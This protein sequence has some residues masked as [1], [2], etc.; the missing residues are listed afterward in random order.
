MELKH[1]LYTR[2]LPGLLGRSVRAVLAAAIALLRQAVDTLPNLA[3]WPLNRTRTPLP[4]T[5]PWPRS[6]RLWRRPRPP[7]FGPGCGCPSAACGAGQ[8]LEADVAGALRVAGKFLVLFTRGLEE[9]LH[10]LGL[11]QPVVLVVAEWSPVC[12]CRNSRHAS[13]RSGPMSSTMCRAQSSSAVLVAASILGWAMTF[14]GRGARP[15]PCHL[16][17]TASIGGR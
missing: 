4:A 10:A 11:R 17:R 15:H 16:R 2:V 12:R 1:L 9:E 6:E 14:C 8:A 7:T 3:I 13:R 5:Q